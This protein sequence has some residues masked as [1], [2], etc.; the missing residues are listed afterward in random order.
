MHSCD[1]KKNIIFC[2]ITTSGWKSCVGLYSLIKCHYPSAFGADY[3]QGLGLDQ[4]ISLGVGYKQGWSWDGVNHELGREFG[5]GIG[6][7]MH[8]MGS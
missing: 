7:G 5:H 4:R 3:H 1:V 2:N 6:H 8:M